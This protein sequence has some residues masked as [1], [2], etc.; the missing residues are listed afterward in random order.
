MAEAIVDRLE[1]VQVDVQRRDGQ[2]PA[3]G[4]REHL[5]NALDGEQAIGRP[6]SESWKAWWRRKAWSTGSLVREV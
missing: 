5:L 2:R 3:P 1:A 4:A 6:V